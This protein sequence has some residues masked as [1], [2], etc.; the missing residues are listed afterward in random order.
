[1]CIIAYSSNS[2]N[3]KLKTILT[4]ELCENGILLLFKYDS[5]SN[6]P[7]DT[8]V[9]T[10]QFDSFH[11]YDFAFNS[12]NIQQ[13]YTSF[14]ALPTIT[15]SY[16][17]DATR[18]LVTMNTQYAN[19]GLNNLGIISVNMS[20]FISPQIDV[21]YAA[22]SSAVSFYIQSSSGLTMRS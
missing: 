15:S 21:Q 14:I 8:K 19:E 9:Q 12:V 17:V 16:Q 7:S 10:T 18:A 11:L 1:M 22:T 2:S 13:L 6:D 4:K 5:N 3:S 20:S